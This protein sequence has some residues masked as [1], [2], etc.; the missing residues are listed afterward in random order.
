L[1][2]DI[3][4]YPEENWR[5][6]PSPIVSINNQSAEQYVQDWSA[7]FP[8]LENHA[9]YNQ[10][11]PN[12]PSISQG[13]GFT[14]EFGRSPYYSGET[15]IVEYKN[16]TVQELLNVASVLKD[17]TGVEDGET[18]FEAFC[19]RGPDGVDSRKKRDVSL[20]TTKKT[21][22]NYRDDVFHREKEAIAATKVKRQESEPT[23]TGYPVAEILHSEAAIGGY[24]LSGQGYEDVAVLAV[25]SF[26]PEDTVQ[27]QDL[28]GTFLETAS[29]AGK[30]K[31]VID[32]RG[33]G[34]G[35]LFLGYD[36]FKQVGVALT[37]LSP[38]F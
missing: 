35:T 28:I 18:F 20:T 14:T 25:P 13:Y 22:F 1:L 27:F 17:F 31:L 8:F 4:F 23:A 29:S 33:N 9:R 12:Q 16:G 26:G 36:M 24:Y 30:T 38:H 15:T 3:L 21:A 19:N 10:L 34:G 5:N 11:F 2:D 6:P 7:R 37:F 32:L